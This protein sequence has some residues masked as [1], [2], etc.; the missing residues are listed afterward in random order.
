MSGF[1]K[2]WNTHKHVLT[3][4]SVGTRLRNQKPDLPWEGST[5]IA[6]AGDIYD[7]RKRQAIMDT[8][9]AYA[10]I[11]V[12]AGLPM[13]IETPTRRA[14]KERMAVSPYN[15]H[16]VIA[17]NVDMMCQAQEDCSH[18]YISGIMGCRGDAYSGKPGLSVE[19]GYAFHSWAV[20]VF[21]RT[22]VDLLY[23]AL[24]PTLPETLGWAKAAASTGLP[25]LISWS[26]DKNGCLLD[27]TPLYDAIA[28]I[29]DATPHAPLAHV[30]NCIHPRFCHQALL[31]PFNRTKN[32]H[33]RFQGLSANGAA[34]ERDA[35]DDNAEICCDEP[36]VWV[37]AFQA[38]YADF[39]LKLLGGCCGTEDAHIQAL[40][41]WAAGM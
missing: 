4:G 20:E 5:G 37:A 39:P 25:Y 12:A 22:N 29:D 9:R 28:A 30:S 35:L 2:T 11:A 7:D 23:A 16:S 38:L 32:V 3:E 8:H 40:A 17:D 36:E 15:S 26:M 21:A 34:M 24:M 14:N 6:M 18:I 19:E 31:Q 10:D 41:A 1:L 27:G 13:I 33:T